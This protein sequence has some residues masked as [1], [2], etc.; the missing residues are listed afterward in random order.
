M[1]KKSYI[2]IVVSAIVSVA[3]TCC[4][5]KSTA[6]QYNSIQGFAQGTTY[7]IVYQD[8][9][10]MSV[11]IDTILSKFDKSLSLFDKESL[12]CRINRGETD[13]V[14]SWYSRSFDISR[15]VYE[16]SNGLFE[17]TL[18]PLIAAYGFARKEQ[19]AELTESEL[20]NLMNI[21][22]FDKVRIEDGRLI[23][24]NAKIQIDFNAIAQGLSVDLVAEMFEAHGIENYM[25]EIGGEIF[26]RGISP[27]GRAWRIGIDSP[28]QGN[29]VSGA[30]LATIVELEGRG[31]ATSGNYRKF[32]DKPSGERITHT[33]DPRTG[34]SA[35]SNILSATIIA[36]TAAMADALAT[37][38]M[39]GG[40]EWAKA[41]IEDLKTTMNVDCL[42]IYA[43]ENGDMQNYATMALN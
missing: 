29:I 4:S 17:P 21:V 12:I 33:I 16:L 30:D 22:G 2:F 40:L 31:L 36:P 41:F 10:D 27:S 18:A 34:H 7:N 38:C 37:A 42:L 35:V 15:E 24:D 23:K 39:V 8:S 32:I 43:D 1:T 19:R 6:P 13:S 5:P 14:D 28:K 26:T 20:K 11:A 9:C 25:V 3:L